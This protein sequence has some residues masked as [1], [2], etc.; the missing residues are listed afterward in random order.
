MLNQGSR[1]LSPSQAAAE[2][3]VSVPTVL[4]AFDAG[5]LRGMRTPLGRVIE[6]DSIQA[7]AGATRS[8]CGCPY[9]V[10]KFPARLLLRRHKPR[11]EQSRALTPGGRAAVVVWGPT[12][13]GGTSVATEERLSG[14]TRRAVEANQHH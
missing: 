12:H 13:T 11:P 10:R 5:R 8:G 4:R 7:G 6:A 3:R 9:R 14:C 1:L 2:L